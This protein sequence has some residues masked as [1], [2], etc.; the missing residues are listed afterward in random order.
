MLPHI[1]EVHGHTG[2]GIF[3]DGVR[4]TALWLHSLPCLHCLAD[5]ARPHHLRNDL[6]Q[7][8]IFNA[9]LIATPEH[10][11]CLA[12]SRMRITVLCLDDLLGE[13]HRHINASTDSDFSLV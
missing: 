3:R 13:G 12:G 7:I 1:T 8:T 6:G 10:L 5:R 9:C 2:K 4:V 11:V